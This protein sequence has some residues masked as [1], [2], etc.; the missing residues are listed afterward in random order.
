M[1]TISKGKVQVLSPTGV[2]VYEAPC[3]FVSEVGT[4][5]V[6]RIL[7]DCT[8]TTYHLTD[9]TDLAEIEK[10]IIAEKFDD[11]EITGEFE[12]VFVKELT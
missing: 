2:A 3:T 6:V 5:R 9:K 4:K 8:W 11:V 12:R 7:E 10:D 1:N